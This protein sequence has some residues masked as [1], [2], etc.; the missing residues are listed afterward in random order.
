MMFLG[1]VVSLF[2][3][4]SKAATYSGVISK[5]AGKV[6][7]IRS[8]NT[9]NPLEMRTLTAEGNKILE[10][11]EPG[12][13]LE[14][15][16]SIVNQALV[17]DSIDFVALAELLGT[18]KNG[19]YWISFKDFSN[20]LVYLSSQATAKK[21]TPMQYS[22]VPGDN[23]SWRIFFSEQDKVISAVLTLNGDVADFHFFDQDSGN[24]K[25]YELTKLSFSHVNLRKSR[26]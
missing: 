10:R 20:A 22:I 21:P 1:L 5:F 16:G 23:N 4:S 11:L 26:R 17:L 15:S 19:P 8:D 2:A 25:V 9:S 3:S 12:D 24:T 6:F 14:G 7:L 18:W 13:F